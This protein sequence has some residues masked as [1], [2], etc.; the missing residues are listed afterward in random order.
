[1]TSIESLMLQ[2]RCHLGYIYGVLELLLC[3]SA[4]SSGTLKST[5][6]SDLF[7]AK[8]S[9]EQQKTEGGPG[10]SQG[11]VCGSASAPARLL[12]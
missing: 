4:N 12:V 8:A 10:S 9:E 2:A 7:P 1:M 5:H 3:C 6:T 11:T